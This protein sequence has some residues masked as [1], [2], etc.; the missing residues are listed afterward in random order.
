MLRMSVEL[1]VNTIVGLWHNEDN[2]FEGEKL[3]RA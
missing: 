1:D 3:P 2:R